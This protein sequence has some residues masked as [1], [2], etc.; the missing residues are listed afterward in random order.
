MQPEFLY[1]A[2]NYPV[3]AGRIRFNKSKVNDLVKEGAQLGRWETFLCG[4]SLNGL[5][6]R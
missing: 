3:L 1:A 2:V 4:H 5:A 6:D